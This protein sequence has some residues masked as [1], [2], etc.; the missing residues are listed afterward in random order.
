MSDPSKPQYDTKAEVMWFIAV[1]KEP[2]WAQDRFL[3]EY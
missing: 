3:H 1:Q 2:S